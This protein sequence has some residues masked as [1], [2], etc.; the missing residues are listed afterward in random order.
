MTVG[1]PLRF[2]G[3]SCTLLLLF[4]AHLGSEWPNMGIDSTATLASA[5]RPRTPLSMTRMPARGLSLPTQNRHVDVECYFRLRCS[6]ITRLHVLCLQTTRDYKPYMY[7]L[8]LQYDTKCVYKPPEWPSGISWMLPAP[9]VS[10]RWCS[11]AKSMYAK[12]AFA[13][14]YA[15]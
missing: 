7:D 6:S 3:C 8:R 12:G 13:L 15:H 11:N 14:R 2:F 9:S 4:H 5:Y 1:S 10:A